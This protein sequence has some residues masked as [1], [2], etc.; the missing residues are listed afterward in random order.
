MVQKGGMMSAPAI[1]M[2]TIGSLFF[3]GG[4]VL[5]ILAIFHGKIL[6]YEFHNPTNIE[7]IRL[8][9]IALFLSIIG[10]S[11]MLYF[12]LTSQHSEMIRILERIYEALR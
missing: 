4:T 5:I 1:V 6:K 8:A 12:Q 7:A 11:M 3:V 9:Y 10:F 2:A